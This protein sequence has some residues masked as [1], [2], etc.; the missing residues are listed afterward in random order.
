MLY[1]LSFL[2]SL[3]LLFQVRGILLD[4]LL[5][6]CDN[7]FLSWARRVS[8]STITLTSVSVAFLWAAARVIY[9]CHGQSMSSTF[10]AAKRRHMSFFTAEGET[11]EKRSPRR[12]NPRTGGYESEEF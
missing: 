4:Q 6:V 11:P 5:L 7:R 10:R 3:I 12:R 9:T 8:A 2:L 1:C